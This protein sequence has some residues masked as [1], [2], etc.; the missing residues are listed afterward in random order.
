[1]FV[2]HRYIVIGLV[3]WVVS[4]A[5]AGCAETKLAQCEKLIGKVNQGISLLEKNKGSQVTTSLQLARDLKEVSKSTQDLNLSDPTLKGYQT[6]FV[7]IFNT[8]SENI[9]KAAK[10]LGTSKNAKADT[11]GRKKI[12]QARNEINTAGKKNEQA[13]KKSDQIANQLSKYCAQKE[14]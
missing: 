5:I 6:Q 4:I 14:L 3:G 1:M 8:V 9:D 2:R 12:K 13:A 10:A 7:D 11:E